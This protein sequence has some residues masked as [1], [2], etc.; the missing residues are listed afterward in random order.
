M[1]GIEGSYEV[2]SKINEGIND[3]VKNFGLYTNLS[4]LIFRDEEV[5]IRYLFSDIEYHNYK[6]ELFLDVDEFLQ[7]CSDSHL[8]DE[9]EISYNPEYKFVRS[10]DIQELK[11]TWINYHRIEIH[12]TERNDLKEMKKFSTLFVQMLTNSVVFRKFEIVYIDI[13]VNRIRVTIRIVD[14]Q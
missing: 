5:V 11:D 14:E 12:F 8:E 6:N 7:N 9:T 1:K 4:P 10:W 2:Q 13:L 3:Y